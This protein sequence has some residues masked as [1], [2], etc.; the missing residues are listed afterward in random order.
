MFGT[1]H[2]YAVSLLLLSISHAASIDIRPN[3][4][5]TFD[6]PMEEVLFRPDGRGF[7]IFLIRT[8]EEIKIYDSTGANIKRLQRTPGD[9]FQI[10]AD[11]SAFM[12]VQS[13]ESILATDQELIY[14][15]QVYDG[16]G[17]RKY[18]SVLGID[19][20]ESTLHY[21]LTE[22]GTLLLNIPDRP[23][24]LELMGDDT[25]NYID[26]CGDMDDRS[27]EPF[28]A[29]S[30]LANKNEVVSAR[31]CKAP[32]QADSLIT[33]LTLW[34][35]DHPILE[36]VLISGS[37][38]HLTSVPS[39]EFYFLEL[40]H[41]DRRSLNLFHRSSPI[42]T[43][44]WGSWQIEKLKSHAVFIVSENDLN[45]VNLSDGTLIASVHPVDLSSVSDA[46]YLEE[47]GVFM[48]LRYESFYSETGRQAFRNFELEGIEKSGRIVHKSSFGSWS[49]MLPKI[50][51][52]GKDLFAIHIY[53]AVLLYRMELN[54]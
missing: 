8:A 30:K 25:L 37:V 1:L 48:Y 42:Q 6:T 32:V 31:T 20:L 51:P 5:W 9:A 36:P 26:A 50:T 52:L 21:Q 47:Y 35:H 14:S 23:W 54:R 44:P 2:K 28:I 33:E 24:L 17:N 22:F 39:S 13:H 4:Q 3:A 15:F 7:P 40:D 27:S 29:V 38:S 19:L 12:L 10:N 34:N 46:C 18:T 49:Y 41:G 11:H 53:N 16:M 43:F 45:V